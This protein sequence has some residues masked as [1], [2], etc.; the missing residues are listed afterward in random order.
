VLVRVLCWYGKNEVDASTDFVPVRAVFWY[1][2]SGLRV[3]TEVVL[4]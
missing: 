3:S 2:E 1:E 4:V